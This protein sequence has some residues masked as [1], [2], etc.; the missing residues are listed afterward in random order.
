MKV[1]GDRTPRKIAPELVETVWKSAPA[2][3][4]LR[5]SARANLRRSVK[6]VL[7]KHGSPPDRQERAPRIV[8]E[9]AEALSGEWGSAAAAGLIRVE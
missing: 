1:L 2:D 3:W 9:Q 7:R 6:R 4:T 5:E 8:I